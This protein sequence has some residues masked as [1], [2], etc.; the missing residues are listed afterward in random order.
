MSLRVRGPTRAALAVA[1]GPLRHP[2]LTDGEVA[3]GPKD[4]HTHAA[5]ELLGLLVSAAEA[6]FRGKAL[7]AAAID[8]SFYF[9]P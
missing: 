3:N 4:R 9:R 6:Y 2:S 1:A 5:R 8:P 7:R